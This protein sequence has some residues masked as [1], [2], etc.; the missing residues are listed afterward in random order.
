MLQAYAPDTFENARSYPGLE[1]QMARAAGTVL[2][3]NH[4]PL[5]ARAQNVQD[6]IE[7]GAIRYAGSAIGSGWF[8]GRQDGFD[9]VPQIIRNLAESIPLLGL[10]AHRIVLHDVT[11]LVSALTCRNREGF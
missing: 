10:L 5:A 3:G 7:H 4:L 2:A 6:T 11:M 9:Q 1:P 8:V